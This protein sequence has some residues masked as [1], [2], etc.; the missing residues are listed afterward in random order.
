MTRVVLD[1]HAI[2]E[3]LNSEHG[4]VGVEIAKRAVRVESTAKRIA[5]VDTGRYRSS[6]THSIERDA[7]GLVAYVGTNVTYALFLEFGTRF[8]RAFATLRTALRS[9]LR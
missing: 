1:Q 3:L 7:R 5:P 8:M 2:S 4:P 9:A 6:I